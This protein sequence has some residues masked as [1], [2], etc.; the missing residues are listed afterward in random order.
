VNQNA[1]PVIVY[2]TIAITGL[3]YSWKV[4]SKIFSLLLIAFSN[5]EPCRYPLAKPRKGSGACG[6]FFC[7]KE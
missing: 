2:L 7:A 4:I 6:A 5:Y 3:F 1:V